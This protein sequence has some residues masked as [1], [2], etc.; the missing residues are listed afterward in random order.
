MSYNQD[1]TYTDDL[2][3]TAAVK[4]AV[5]P[6]RGTWGKRDASDWGSMKGKHTQGYVN[7]S[8]YPAVN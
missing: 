1:F 5:K 4:K 6:L 7:D 3:G 8:D 2:N